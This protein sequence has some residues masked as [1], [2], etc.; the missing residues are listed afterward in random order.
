LKD[1]AIANIMAPKNPEIVLFMRSYLKVFGN[2]LFI[3]VI[4]TGLALR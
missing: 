2:G 3:G 1:K 4:V